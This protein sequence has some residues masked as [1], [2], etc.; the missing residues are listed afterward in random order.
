MN[1]SAHPAEK[2]GTKIDVN[3]EYAYGELIFEG[4]RPKHSFVVWKNAR[5]CM[6]ADQGVS[7]AEKGGLPTKEG[8]AAQ[9]GQAGAAVQQQIRELKEAVKALRE[10]A[11]LII[12]W[13]NRLLNDQMEKLIKRNLEEACKNWDWLVSEPLNLTPLRE[14]IAATERFVEENP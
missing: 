10:A 1:E 12:E 7:F 5:E 14:T 2:G 11:L 9:T 8:L 6:Q 4:G 13:E 3:P